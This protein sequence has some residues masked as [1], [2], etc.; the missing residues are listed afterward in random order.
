LAKTE[1]DRRKVVARLVR[2]GWQ[3]RGGGEH[4]I[5]TRADRPGIII[6][7]LRHRTLSPGVARV[8]AE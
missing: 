1:T 6:A 5:Y 8:R 3:Y 2:D 4:D 7:V